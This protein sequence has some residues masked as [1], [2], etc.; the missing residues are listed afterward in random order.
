MTNDSRSQRATAV[1]LVRD[2][3][4]PPSSSSCVTR[5]S[6]AEQVSV[7]RLAQPRIDQGTLIAV[8][9]HDGQLRA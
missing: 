6:L 2:A 4:A 7:M 1:I 8:Y 5:G 9:S 3:R